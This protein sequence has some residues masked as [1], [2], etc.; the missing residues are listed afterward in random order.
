MPATAKTVSNT[1]VIIIAFFE[2]N[3]LFCFCIFSVKV[4][5][6]GTLP[7]GLTTTK[8]EMTAFRRSSPKVSDVTNKL[9]NLLLILSKIVWFCRWKVHIVIKYMETLKSLLSQN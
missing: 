4:T 8:S 3:P 6:S 9:E 1:A 7:T 5:N 2:T